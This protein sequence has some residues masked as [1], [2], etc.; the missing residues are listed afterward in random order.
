MR[1]NQGA[2]YLLLV[3]II[4]LILLSGCAFGE[5]VSAGADAF[6]ENIDMQ[7]ERAGYSDNTYSDK[8]ST[9]NGK[10]ICHIGDTVYVNDL[11]YGGFDL[12]IDSVNMVYDSFS[13]K[14]LFALNYTV[15]NT[16][17]DTLHF[18]PGYIVFYGDDYAI[19]AAANGDDVSMG[20]TI[21][22][23]RKS[24][25]TTY[26]GHFPSEYSTFEAEIG[27]VVID[28]T[29]V[30]VKKGTA[31]TSQA[32]TSKQETKSSTNVNSNNQSRIE[33][34]DILGEP[35][36]DIARQYGLTKVNASDCIEYHNEGLCI[37][38]DMYTENPPIRDIMLTN[39]DYSFC[40]IY[41]GMDIG[42][43]YD[44]C[45]QGGLIEI[46]DTYSPGKIAFVTDDEAVEISFYSDENACV[47]KI[48]VV[49]NCLY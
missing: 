1:K 12:T 22:P 40:G 41:C 49:A 29:G 8:T 36:E 28:L 6:K 10:V 44:I 14:N 18:H 39:S 11:M 9:S 23:S 24:K 2:V 20:S 48:F 25:E 35:I 45:E 34:V 3:S 4:S 16:S 47:S 46:V 13:E 42:D 32:E 5:A 30:E 19:E 26:C 17:N 43:A 21:A 31:T 15:T 38:G 37:D 33:V 7:K 27:N